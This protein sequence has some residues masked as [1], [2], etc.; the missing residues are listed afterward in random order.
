MDESKLPPQPATPSCRGTMTLPV[1]LKLMV[2]IVDRGRGKLVI[3][4]L[5]KQGIYF[6]L[7]VLGKGTA[8]SE[9]LD[10]LGVGETEK[11]IVLSISKSDKI[12]QVMETLKDNLK[13]S[14]P[15]HGIAFTIP[16]LSVGG[17]LTLQFIAGEE[18]V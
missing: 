17:K 3:E 15:G 1:K 8:K 14:Q 10:L 7:T 4:A 11:D 13:F 16:V 9:L 5:R 2:T 18:E 12:R 6:H